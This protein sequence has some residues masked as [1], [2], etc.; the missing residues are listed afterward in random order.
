VHPQHRDLPHILVYSPRGDEAAEY[1]RL[2]VERHPEAD[3]MSA[4]EPAG[5]FRHIGSAEVLMGWMFPANAFTTVRRLRWIHKI[6]AGV[7]DVI[8]EQPHDPSV[9]LT[10]TPGALIAPRM[11][12]YVL[13][14]IYA[15]AQRFD[16]AA[17]QQRE[18]VW[19]KYT[20]DL[21]SQCTVG[22]AGLGDIGMLVVSALRRNGFRVLGWRRTPRPADGVE[23]VYV[24]TEELEPFVAACDVIVILLPATAATQ[25]IISERVLAAM[26]P[27]AY[28]INIARGSVVDEAALIRALRERRIAGAA[29]DVFEVE[30]LPVD[31]PLW[32]LPN[33]R[34][35]PHVSGPVIPA[36]VVG[37]FLDNLERYLAGQPLKR[38]IDETQGY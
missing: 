10:R 29:L 2:I 33:V 1:S 9:V 31:S 16:L 21:A 24:G 20:P 15:H 25:R 14:C 23:Q 18:R 36:E 32:E 38:Q 17:A 5:F 3:L 37:A 35:T 8:Y 27:E 34:L 19:H 22:V 7:E 12:E 4:S 30:P 11:V 28:L 6:S 13:G 26:K